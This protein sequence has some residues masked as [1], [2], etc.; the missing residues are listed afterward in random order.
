MGGAGKGG[1][2]DP[3]PDALE[4]PRAHA[5]HRA[6]LLDAAERAVL[7]SEVDDAAREH[8]ADPGQ[9]VEVGRV[10]AVEI[11]RHGAHAGRCNVRAA[12]SR[13]A[14]R[15]LSSGARAGGGRRR[16][17]GTPRAP[18][19]VGGADRQQQQQRERAASLCGVQDQ[20]PCLPRG[21]PTS[22]GRGPLQSG[23]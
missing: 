5:A 8:R 9:R 21:G 22:G 12:K 6:Q 18:Q 13:G 17:D 7:A 23:P 11:E 20:R 2:F 15:V 10:G 3:R 1:D 16:G 4:Q 14:A 19:V